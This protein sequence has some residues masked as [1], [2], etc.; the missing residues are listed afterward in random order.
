MP[1][2]VLVVDDEQEIRLLLRDFLTDEG[3]EVVT[4]PNGKDALGVAESMEPAVIL[5]DMSMP[6]MDGWAFARA[7]RMLTRNPAPIVVLTAG[8][9]AAERAAEVEAASFLAKP[10][11]IDELLAVVQ[12][13]TPATHEAGVDGK[14][15][16]G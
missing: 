7:Y 10:F 5:L 6:I 14:E 1:R 15:A 4:A 2:P 8:G 13:F 12:R 16:A 3:Y 11:D 9:L